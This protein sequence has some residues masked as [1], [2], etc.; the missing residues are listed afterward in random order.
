MMGLRR[1]PPLAMAN[2]VGI[3]RMGL[4]WERSSSLRALLI[5]PSFSPSLSARLIR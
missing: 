1:F 4:T 5:Y 3:W 2:F